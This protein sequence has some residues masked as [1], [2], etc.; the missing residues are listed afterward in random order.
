MRL[1]KALSDFAQAVPPVATSLSPYM[2]QCAI[3]VCQERYPE[4]LDRRYS[5]FAVQGLCNGAV[6]FD[7]EIVGVMMPLKNLSDAAQGG[8]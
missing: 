2:M 1:L 4:L 8:A 7:G 5:R 6:T 3:S